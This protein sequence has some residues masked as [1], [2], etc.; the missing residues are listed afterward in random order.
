MEDNILV[1]VIF[2]FLA[3]M[4]DGALG[5]AYGVSSTTLLLSLG[6]PAAAASASVHMA[7]VCT[8][9][10]SGLSHLKLGNVDKHL[11]QRLVIAGVLGGVIGHTYSPRY[12]VTS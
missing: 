8:T 3:Q 11:F 1:F 4:I 6:I 7:E 2:G 9:A 12:Q 5:M 10:V